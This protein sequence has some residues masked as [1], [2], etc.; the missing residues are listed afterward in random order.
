MVMGYSELGERTGYASLFDTGTAD[1]FA[2]RQRKV[3]AMMNPSEWAPRGSETRPLKT[4]LN[5]GSRDVRQLRHAA[6]RA[7]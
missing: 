7:D 6:V 4:T 5:L 3:I 2:R 1:C